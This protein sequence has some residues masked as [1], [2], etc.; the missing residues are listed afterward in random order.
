M[1]AN[2]PQI[3]PLH[4]RTVAPQIM[5]TAAEKKHS[6]NKCV[7]ESLINEGE[8]KVIKCVFL[9]FGWSQEQNNTR[10]RRTP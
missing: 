7:A 1:D 10:K 4:R 6:F 5:K 8:K 2:T 9:C 3:S